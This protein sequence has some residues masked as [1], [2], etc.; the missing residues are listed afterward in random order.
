MDV[1]VDDYT[2]EIETNDM[3]DVFQSLYLKNIK[4]DIKSILFKVSEYKKI[5]RNHI[6]EID[7]FEQFGKYVIKIKLIN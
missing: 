4:F 3:F 2:L 1:D 6:R 5:I 7:K